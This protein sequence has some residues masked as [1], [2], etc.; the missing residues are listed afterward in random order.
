MM[1]EGAVEGGPGL[2]PPMV[3]KEAR[4]SR[5]SEYLRVV[6]RVLKCLKRFSTI[7]VVVLTPMLSRISFKTS[8][9]SVRK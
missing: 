3:R 5:D 7:S 4:V 1:D 6:S 9:P 2:G 8:I